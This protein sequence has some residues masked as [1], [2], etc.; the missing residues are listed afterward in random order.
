M[1][2]TP[3]YDWKN[4]FEP[5]IRQYYRTM[6]PDCV[7]MLVGYDGPIPHKLTIISHATEMG[8]AMDPE[9]KRAKQRKPKRQKNEDGVS[10]RSVFEAL[11]EVLL[12]QR[13]RRADP[14]VR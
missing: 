4:V 9:A 8:Y 2:F 7:T 13:I 3:K 12:V 1:T 14:T 10:A 5:N 11:A 6:G